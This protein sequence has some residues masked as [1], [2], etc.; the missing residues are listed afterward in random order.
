MHKKIVQSILDIIEK[1]ITT[2]QF[3]NVETEIVEL[4]DLSTG[5]DWKSLKETICAFLNSHDGIIITGIREREKQYSF[6]G[7]N[8]NNLQRYLDLRNA[9]TDDIGNSIDLI[10]QLQFEIRPFLDRK[11]KIIYVSSVSDDMKF[12]FFNDNAFERKSTADISVSKEKILAQ[13][14]YKLE[15]LANRKEITPIPNSSVTNLSIGKLNDYIQYL[16]R[17]VKVQ[18]LFAENDYE[19]IKPF[20][21]KKYF[22]KK[23]E[24]T[25]LGMLVCGEDPAHFLEFRCE[26]DCF[27]D[28]PLLVT[29]NKK[30]ISETVIPLMEESYRFVLNNIEVGVSSEKSGTKLPEYP[31]EVIRESLNNALAHRDYTSNKNTN[32]SIRPNKEIEI[33]NPGQLKEKLIIRSAENGSLIRR[34]IPGNPSTQNPKLASILKVFDKW[35]G[36][37]YGM[38]T[39][40]N[41][42]LGDKIGIPFYKISL[43]EIALVIPKGNLRDERAK[44]WL[45]SYWRYITKKLG[46]DPTLEQEKV[47]I[48]LYKSEILNQE[49]KYTILLTSD[50]DLYNTVNTLLPSGL[51]YKSVQSHLLY[52]VYLVD[53][54]LLKK[55]FDDELITLFGADYSF[56]KPYYKKALNIIYRY[57]KFNN[58][59]IT[60]KAVADELFLDEGGDTT[61]TTFVR[62]ISDYCSKMSSNKMNLLIKSKGYR[63]NFNFAMK[64]SL[65]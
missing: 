14:Q 57:S 62:K 63:I 32:I 5:T 27:V 38:A 28:S 40:V 36:K 19:S 26:V 24:V 61:Y 51:I 39:L 46:E 53:R 7:Y 12:I 65:F 30:V 31:I 45:K 21:N 35:E 1:S 60:A 4:K 10:D 11:I 58:E 56:L 49:E 42:C 9:F 33:K 15:E 6:P 20:L 54:I 18:N 8:E 55:K 64:E 16:N 17:E 44:F 34:I 50:N 25:N 52:P 37:G 22:I 41:T 2:G 48:Y 23:D 59:P 13:R 47:L 3:E 43:E 29:K